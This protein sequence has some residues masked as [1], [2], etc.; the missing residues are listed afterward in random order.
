MSID[1]FVAGP[2]G[3][4]DWVGTIASDQAIGNFF[5]EM[6][7]SSDTL[8]LGRKTA[9]EVVST[10]EDIANNKPDSPEYPV[11]KK[12][13]KI[14]KI[15]FSK[16]QSEISG[17]NLKV[18]SG[19]LVTAIQ[20][21]KNKPGM[22]ILVYGGV[23]FVSELISH[24]LIDEYHL[25]INPVSLGDGLGIFQDKKSLELI[26]SVPFKNGIVVNTYV[27]AS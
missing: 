6:L 5:S 26:K 23:R 21:L 22:D 27:N 10:W 13:V 14:S 11:A 2:E 9:I 4:L 17:K 3:Q 8:I 15:A 24:N 18:E 20:A 12:I 19:D 25:L 7:D 16:S 1:G